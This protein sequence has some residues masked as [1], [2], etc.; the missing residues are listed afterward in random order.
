MTNQIFIILKD[1]L[2]RLTSSKLSELATQFG[3]DKLAH[4]YIDHYQH[5][6]AHLRLRKL[7]ILEIGI[8]EGASLNMWQTYFPHSIIH[9]IDIREKDQFTSARVKIYQG[10]QGDPEFL[11]Q[12]A[13]KAGG[14]DIV[15]DDGSHKSEHVITSFRTLFPL[16]KPEGI[17]AIE[18]LHTAYW[19]A[20]GGKW[21]NLESGRTSMT[22]LKSLLDG[23]NCHWI[24]GREPDD[25]DRQ[26]TA[27][28]TYPKLAFIYKGK[29]PSVHRPYELKMMQESLTDVTGK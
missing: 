26:I 2:S 21:R 9:A 15:I 5:H 12:V 28:H 6:F 14:F 23:L 16:L 8:A 19:T 4:G 11:R 29:N 1:C 13:A 24:P 25:F 3:T 20:Y 17:Y 22:L 18:D 7:S 10:D 27:I